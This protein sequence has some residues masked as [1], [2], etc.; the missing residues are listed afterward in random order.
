MTSSSD[1][2]VPRTYGNWRQA[3]GIG[4]GSWST[5]QTITAFVAVLIPIL[6]F[7]TSAVAGV[8]ALGAALLTMVIVLVPVGGTSMWALVARRA[9]FSSARRAGW[10]RYTGGVLTDHPRKN[11]LPGP[12]API[13]PLDSDDGRGG[14]QAILWDRRT[15]LLTVVLRCSPGGL[16]L[17]DQKQAD[18]WVASWGAWLADLGYQPMIRWVSVTVDTAP[19][20]GTTTREYVAGRRSPHAPPAANAVLDELLASTP[21]V[22]AD[23]DTRVSITFDP[24]RA[25]PRPQDLLAAVAEV[26]RWVPGLEQG[27]GPCGVTVLGR[28]TVP[29][30]V[31]RL[32]TAYDPAARGDVAL[33]DDRQQILQWRDAD[34]V[35]AEETR[36]FFQHDSGIS[37]SWAM[38]EAPRQA[39]TE[40]VLTPLLAPGPHPRRFTL[41]YEPFPADRAAVEVEREVTA[42]AV[43]N[44]WARRTKRDPRQRDRDDADRAHQAAREES[45]GA[46]VGRFCVYVTT[47]VHDPERL[48][49]AVADVELRA[50][51]SKLRLRRLWWAQ[52]AGFAAALGLGIN[53]LELEHRRHG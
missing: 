34:P 33:L 16:D 32:R 28:A 10:T 39:V 42:L 7:Y 52:G 43:R 25:N 9:R 21:R 41:L 1:A 15:G 18:Q 30:L 36:E 29:W 22:T 13:T 44:E 31:G 8:I 53:P 49:A 4:I 20:G 24:S 50:G 37:V 17:A 35:H 27:L 26:T 51:Q 11:M 47:T 38:R 45:Q 2:A 6:L 19:T 3:K 12:M 23:V 5:S 48:P 40:R 46:G 14:R